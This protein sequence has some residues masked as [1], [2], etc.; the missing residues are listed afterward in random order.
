MLRFIRL[1]LVDRFYYQAL[2]AIKN[3]LRLQIKNCRDNDLDNR[4]QSCFLGELIMEGK[5]GHL[6]PTLL[7]EVQKVPLILLT[8]MTSPEKLIKLCFTDLCCVKVRKC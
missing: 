3:V 5:M 2:E 8:R 7:S 6:D 1:V 4:L